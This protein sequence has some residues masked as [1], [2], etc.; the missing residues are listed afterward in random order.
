MA[1]TPSRFASELASFWKDDFAPLKAAGQA[2]LAALREQEEA[3]DA[4][5]YRRITASNPGSHLY[6]PGSESSSCVTL[7]WKHIRS[8]PL[9]PFLAQ[10]LSTVK[11]HSLM[12]LLTPASLVWMSVDHKLY[13]W[14]F[15]HQEESLSR[16]EVPSRQ[17]VVSVGL[18][19]PKK[20]TATQHSL[21][22]SHRHYAVALA[23]VLLTVLYFF[24][25]CLYGCS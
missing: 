8:D 15:R 10:Q 20:G 19:K 5:L 7:Q 17:C 1:S 25:R 6:F 11:I 18:V 21:A 12:G 16:F 3:P 14:P 22:V 9:P 13:L 4:D 2:V 24:P 23:S